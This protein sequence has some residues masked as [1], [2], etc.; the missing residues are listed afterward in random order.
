MKKTIYLVLLFGAAFLALWEQS[1]AQPN[2]YLMVGAIV[3]FMLG[4][5]QLMAKVP[6]KNDK[7]ND[8]ES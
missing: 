3:V 4:L 6:S 8:R 1:K 5:M 7:D 2:N